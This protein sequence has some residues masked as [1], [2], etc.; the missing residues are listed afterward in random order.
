MNTRHSNLTDA[1]INVLNSL[2]RENSPERIALQAKKC[3][4]DYLGVTFAG[5]KIISDQGNRI[6]EQFES[7]DKTATV[8][9]FNKKTNIHNAAL[10]NGL[11]SHVAE[12]DDGDRFGMVHPGSTVIS[13]LFAIAERDRINGDQ[14]IK[15]VVVGYE[16]VIRIARALQPQLKKRG[17]H[18][19]GLCGS[20][21]AAMGIA[22][23][24]NY[25]KAEMKDALSAAV[26]NSSGI[27]NVIRDGSDLKPYNAG[28]AALSGVLAA[29]I[30][31]AGFK[32]PDDVLNGYQGFL[33]L[34][35]DEIKYSEVEEDTN[36]RYRIEQI[37]R[38]PYA[39]CRHSHPAIEAVLSLRK[40][41][42][43]KSNEIKEIRV[44]TYS[45]AVI[46]HDHI[47]VDGITSAK[48]STP[49]SVVVA[50]E[51]GN[52]GL[53]EFLP[54]RIDDSRVIALTKRVKVISDDNLTAQVPQ[55][56]PA[57]V[58][59][60]TFDNKSYVEKVDLPKGEPEIPLTEREIEDKFINLALF[61]GKSKKDA[62]M[63]IQRV[64]NVESEL[65][66]LH[67]LL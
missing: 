45:L 62:D 54:E 11:L 20:I 52:A 58:E 40:Q 41:F 4:L 32:G 48:M 26:T 49:Y 5:S 18:A 23:A 13:A 57:I 51:T 59:I 12:L 3:I 2:S 9:G 6:L 1:Y 64:C 47:L 65:G 50:F 33:S 46:G 67:E 63:I 30:A 10:I 14:F 66:K 38:K 22:A 55:K 34:I 31:R 29:Y 37:Y 44:F 35:T 39:A 15:G 21:G 60:I 53:D 61:S 24:L 19:T 25:S 28:Q 7:Y 43:I 16:A 36:G 42:D 56:R 17:Y 8:I 27:L